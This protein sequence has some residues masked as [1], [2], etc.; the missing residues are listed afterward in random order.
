MKENDSQF[1]H[2]PLKKEDIV[3]VRPCCRVPES[4]LQLMQIT[5]GERIHLTRFGFSFLP[6]PFFFKSF[7]PLLFA[8]R[9]T[10]EREKGYVNGIAVYLLQPGIGKRWLQRPQRYFE[11]SART[12]TCVLLSF[13]SFRVTV[14]ARHTDTLHRA[15]REVWIFATRQRLGSNIHPRCKAKKK[16]LNLFLKSSCKRSNSHVVHLQKHLLSW[17]LSFINF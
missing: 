10:Y 14:I 2:R 13:F 9:R 5:A 3:T 6:F 11:V 17:T 12:K 15:K 4:F 7:L 16:K 1:F 8:Q